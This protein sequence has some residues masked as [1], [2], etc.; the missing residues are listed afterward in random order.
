MNVLLVVALICGISGFL[1]LVL[2]SA[3]GVFLSDS[4]KKMKN[5]MELAHKRLDEL[6]E[7]EEALKK[8]KEA[9]FVMG[10]LDDRKKKEQHRSIY[11]PVEKPW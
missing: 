3:V 7:E 2:L 1:A 9:E 11:D 8:K 5:N 6:E 10:V 4:D